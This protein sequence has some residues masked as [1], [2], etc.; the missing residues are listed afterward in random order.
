MGANG[1]SEI[2]VNF[3]N[4]SLVYYGGDQVSGTV[5]FQ[6]NQDKLRIDYVFLDFTGELGYVSRE[7]RQTTQGRQASRAGETEVRNH[8]IS[9]LTNRYPVVWPQHGQVS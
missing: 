9:F 1:S 8:Q 2:R 3:N 5:E 7:P 6:N 4:P